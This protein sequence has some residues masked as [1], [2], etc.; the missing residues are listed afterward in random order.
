VAT[1]AAAPP[2]LRHR[3]LHRAAVSAGAPPAELTRAHVLEVD[4]LLVGW[5]GQRWI[6]LPGPLRALRR[7]GVL[8]LETP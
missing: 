3:V 5:R 7:D 4:K 2:S 1:L 6:D 8:V